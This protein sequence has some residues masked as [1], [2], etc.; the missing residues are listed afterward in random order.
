MWNSVGLS[1]P[2]LGGAG[3]GRKESA[4]PEYWNLDII[5]LVPG[6]SPVTF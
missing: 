5:I 3:G 4:N 6:F 1:P 2:S